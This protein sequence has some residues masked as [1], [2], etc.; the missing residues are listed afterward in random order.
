MQVRRTH[1]SCQTCR[2][3][4]ILSKISCSIRLPKLQ[5]EDSWPLNE[6]KPEGRNTKP[7]KVF[8]GKSNH[9]FI[10]LN[11]KIFIRTDIIIMYMQTNENC[12]LDLLGGHNQDNPTIEWWGRLGV[13]FGQKQ[14]KKIVS[15]FADRCQCQLVKRG[16]NSS[17][18]TCLSKNSE[19][20][21]RPNKGQNKNWETFK[22]V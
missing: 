3:L 8:Y 9:V 19:N 13:A 10:Y 11:P 14:F 20:K 18:S 5:M 1:G 4:G 21:Q 2:H 15:L 17:F 6:T 12:E 7:S 22:E 16:F